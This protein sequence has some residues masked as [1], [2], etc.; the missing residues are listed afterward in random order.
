MH[1]F[2]RNSKIKDI[3]FKSIKLTNVLRQSIQ[4]KIDQRIP[5][6]KN[7]TNQK[8]YEDFLKIN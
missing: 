5:I 8:K 3:Q 1:S 2:H 6:K 7:N 4:N